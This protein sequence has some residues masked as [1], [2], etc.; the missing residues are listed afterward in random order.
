MSV[1]VAGEAKLEFLDIDGKV[2]QALA[3]QTAANKP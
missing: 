1:S 2:V 3:P